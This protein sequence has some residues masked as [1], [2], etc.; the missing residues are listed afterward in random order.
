[1][2]RFALALV[3]LLVLAVGPAGAGR[4]CPWSIC[5]GGGGSA[6]GG[7]D[8]P[9]D[10]AG[11][12]NVDDDLCTGQQGEGWFDTTDLRWEFCNADAGVPNV[13]PIGFSSPYYCIDSD[14]DGTYCEAAE[15]NLTINAPLGTTGDSTHTGNLTVTGTL[16][17]TVVAAAY[18]GAGAISVDG[19]NCA[20]PT[21]ATPT[22]SGPKT[23]VITC[24]DNDSSTMQ[25]SMKMPDGW[26]GGTVTFRLIIQQD[27]AST[28]AI[29]VDFAA[30]CVSHDEA[31][32]AWGSPPTGEQPADITLTAANDILM[33]A[34]PAVTVAG[35]TCA[36][37][38]QLFWIG[39]VDATATHADFATAVNILGVE[40][41]YTTTISN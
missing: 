20:I 15:P 17:T 37:G 5:G 34:T 7:F 3:F 12:G 9:F 19:S 22:A 14:G 29:Q 35:T 24:G 16:T 30:Q 1:M 27:A 31:L 41:E 8:N 4:N 25:G 36:A 6:G 10:A 38:D 18:W 21:E 2:K 13:I 23:Y 26:N 40:M 33:D 11:A 32:A 28:N 39:G